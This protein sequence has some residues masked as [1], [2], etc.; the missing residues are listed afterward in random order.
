MVRRYAGILAGALAVLVGACS[1]DSPTSASPLPP[2][3]PAA[4]LFS[5]GTT[6]FVVNRGA[7]T[8]AV[9]NTGTRAIEEEIAVGGRPK[10][11]AITPDGKFVYVTVGQDKVIAVISVASRS[12]VATIDAPSGPQGIAITPDGQFAYVSARFAGVEVFRLSDNTL[13]K[14]ITSEFFDTSQE[15]AITPSG[16]HVY[17]ANIAFR[18]PAPENVTVIETATNTVVA[19]VD[20]SALVNN[21]GPWGVTVLP[22]G[23]K[24]YSNDGDDGE[25]VFQIDSDPSS[26]TF[27]EVTDVIRI[28]NEN[29][30]PRG[31]ESGETAVGVRVYAALSESDEV[32]V[33]DPAT[34]LVTD[35][36]DTGP[37]SEPLRVRLNPDGSELWV[38]LRRGDAVL[39]LDTQTNTEIARIEGFDQPNDIVFAVP[40][41]TPFDAFDIEE[42]EVELGPGPN[43]DEFE[44]EGSFTLGSGDGIDPRSEDVT[45]KVGTFRVTFPAGSFELD[46]DEFEGVIDGVKLEFEIEALGGNSFEFEV[47]GEDADLT[48][49]VNPV[50][51]RLTIGD[52]TGTTFVTADIEEDDEDED[53]DDDDEDDEDEDEDDDEE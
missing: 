29:N 8:V 9:V 30:G 52:D 27:N 42:A 3:A 41:V 26:A 43:D 4:R 16:S 7:G 2:A 28:G 15:L 14:T 34:N 31:M 6:A 18:G 5:D 44:V 40:L 12:V 48:G 13:F 23:K 36:V 11:L 10:S 53:E 46:D 39:I 37:G 50:E 21:F 17:V 38:A 1:Q 33:I 49:T 47:E 35:R 45:L 20:V 51:V 24:V 19:A 22:D 32:V 25:F